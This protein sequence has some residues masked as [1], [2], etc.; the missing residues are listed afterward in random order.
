M[1]GRTAQ[2]GVSKEQGILVPSQVYKL[3]TTDRCGA[4]QSNTESLS[5]K[6]LPGREGPGCPRTKDVGRLPDGPLKALTSSAKACLLAEPP[7][8]ASDDRKPVS[9]L[10]F[11]FWFGI[12]GKDGQRLEVGFKVGKQ[13]RGEKGV[14]LLRL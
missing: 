13:A 12:V 7:P 6:I 3:L 8:Q 5:L 4:T 9:M 14:V 10:A 11:V 1:L 2:S